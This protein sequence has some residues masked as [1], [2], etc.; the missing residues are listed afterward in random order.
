MSIAKKRVPAQVSP[1]VSTADD[2]AKAGLTPPTAQEL[3]DFK[4][5]K[6]TPEM[7]A[8]EFV[9]LA[10]LTA[11]ALEMGFKLLTKFI[12]SILNYNP[13]PQYHAGDQVIYAKVGQVIRICANNVDDECRIYMNDKAVGGLSLGE[14]AQFLSPEKVKPGVNN[15]VC[16]LR[17]SGGGVYGIDF[18]ACRDGQKNWES[19][20]TL[21]S[22]ELPGFHGSH[23]ICIQVYGQ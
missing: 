3:E 22:S 2:Y 21:D 17:N 7:H 23:M 19:Q 12:E 5:F 1:A 4:N 11:W 8:N 13:E 20:K 18:F 6:P 14:T 9:L 16:E 10:A 15:I